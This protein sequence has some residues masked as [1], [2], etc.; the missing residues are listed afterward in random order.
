[1]TPALINAKRIIFWDLFRKTRLFSYKVK[2]PPGL[3]VWPHT[4]HV[5]IHFNVIGKSVTGGNDWISRNNSSH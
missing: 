4:H 5:H 3:F 2:A 1:M